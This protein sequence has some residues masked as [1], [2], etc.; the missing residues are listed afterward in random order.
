MEDEETII[1][2]CKTETVK[3]KD[4]NLEVRAKLDISGLLDDA[5]VSINE[6]ET[7]IENILQNCLYSVSYSSNIKELVLILL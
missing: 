4:F 2:R 3:M 1:L 5:Y 6:N 7:N